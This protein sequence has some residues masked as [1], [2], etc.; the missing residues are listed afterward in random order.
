[1]VFAQNDAVGIAKWL[2]QLILLNQRKLDGFAHGIDPFCAR[3]LYRRDAIRAG[4]AL[5]RVN[6]PLQKTRRARSGAVGQAEF[7][8]QQV[9]AD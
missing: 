1:L 9:K 6:S 8:E 2:T 4:A 5:R 3:G 7:S